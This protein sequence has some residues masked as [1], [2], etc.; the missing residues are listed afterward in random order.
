MAENEKT[1]IWT[2]GQQ[3]EKIFELYQQMALQ[4]QKLGITNESLE[5]LS[6]DLKDVCICLRDQDKRIQKLEKEV[7]RHSVWIGLI[8]L[9]VGALITR[10]INEIWALCK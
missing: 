6:N 1:G 4:N 5:K 9:G 8:T 2:N 7:T 10:F 3:D